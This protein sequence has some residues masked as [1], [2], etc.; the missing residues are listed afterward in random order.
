M[1]VLLTALAAL[2]LLRVKIAFALLAAPFFGFGA[3]KFF[4][5]LFF[6]PDWS[7]LGTPVFY[8]RWAFE[9]VILFSIGNYFWR[10]FSG[11]DFSDL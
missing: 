9:V 11:R 5:G 3:Y 7:F 2:G 6:A 8:I 4:Q 10:K 1:F